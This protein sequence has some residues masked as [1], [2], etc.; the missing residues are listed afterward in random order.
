MLWPD[1]TSAHYA[2][3]VLDYLIENSINHVDKV[4][5]PANLPECRPIEDFWSI[6]K[7]KVYANNWVAKDIQSL[8]SRIRKKLKEVEP[9]TIQRLME[10]V[11]KRIDTVRRRSVIENSNKKI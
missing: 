3:T 5:N 2:E 1:L 7:S 10:G 8:R 4:D 9:S 11:V 6:L